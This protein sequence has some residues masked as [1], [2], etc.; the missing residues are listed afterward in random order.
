MGSRGLSVVGYLRT[1]RRTLPN[2]ELPVYRLLIVSL[3]SLSLSLSL[4]LLVQAEQL[5]GVRDDSGA[6]SKN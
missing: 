4:G 2:V 3:L 6:W 5:A 1:H